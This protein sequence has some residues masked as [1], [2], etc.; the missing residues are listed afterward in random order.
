MPPESL[1]EDFTDFYD[2][3]LM[4]WE[5]VSEKDDDLLEKLP[6]LCLDDCEEEELV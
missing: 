6:L 2:D 3:Y 1:R 5:L 4:L